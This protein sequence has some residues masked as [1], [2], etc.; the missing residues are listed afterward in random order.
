MAHQHTTVRTLE[1]PVAGSSA[2]SARRALTTALTGSP[3]ES[4]SGDA[5]LAI[6]ELVTN[7]VLHARE[8][9]T[10]TIWVGDSEVVVRVRDGSPLSPS[11]SMLDPTAVTGRGLVLVSAVADAFGVDAV[12]GGKEVWF[13]LTRTDIGEKA[14]V[15]VDELL[16]SW[17]DDLEIDPAK[18]AV[19]VVITDL[20]V[21]AMIACEAHTEGVLREMAITAASS[22]GATTPA[23]SLLA[24]A[25]PLDAM[26]ADVRRQ[27]AHAV[28]RSRP[29]LDIRLT[30]RREDAE[31]VRGLMHTLDHADRLS[32]R[33]E[34]LSLPTPAPISETRGSFLRRL[35]NQLLS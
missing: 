31:L 4:R 33:G 26:R 32:R 25:T 2:P 12:E 35:L 18:E 20:D 22:E 6:S 28:R 24:A 30:V 17:A 19:R 3:F 10:V 1:L 29:T 11:F 27:L 15:D 16:A 13:S 9:I 23:H 21:A 7:A 8:P 34:L 5:A 14:T